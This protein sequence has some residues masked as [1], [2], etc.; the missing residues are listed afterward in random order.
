MFTAV[1]GRSV[2]LL[3]HQLR[4]LGPILIHLHPTASIR[5]VE[6]MYLLN[7]ETL[8]TSTAILTR[9]PGLQWKV[10]REKTGVVWVER[11]KPP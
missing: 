4:S 1:S 5:S 3:R 9:Q 7:I 10:D 6:H 8:G 11:S 2:L